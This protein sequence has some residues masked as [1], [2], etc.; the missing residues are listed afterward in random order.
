MSLEGT[1]GDRIKGSVLGPLMGGQNS[2]MRDVVSAAVPLP[3]RK[4]YLQVG[5]ELVL[6]ESWFRS[7]HLAKF[8]AK[9]AFSVT[10]S[11]CRTF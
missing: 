9:R 11:L 7:C 10:L 8:L 5:I 6:L 3:L 4:T 1:R 2:R